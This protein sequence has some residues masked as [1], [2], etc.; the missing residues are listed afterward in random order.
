MLNLIIV[1]TM[2]PDSTTPATV[3]IV[4]GALNVK[5]AYVFDL[6]A[7]CAGFVYGLKTAANFLKD[8]KIKYVLLIEGVVLETNSHPKTLANFKKILYKELITLKEINTR[9]FAGRTLSTFSKILA[10][11]R[12]RWKDY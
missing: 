9:T 7:A 4:Q 11:G 2:S 3:A 8:P 5:N 1:A 12:M 10:Q 6:S